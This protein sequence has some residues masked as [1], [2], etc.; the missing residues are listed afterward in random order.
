VLGQAELVWEERPR[1]GRG[2]VGRRCEWKQAVR[3]VLLGR[4]NRQGGKGAAGGLGCLG[5]CCSWVAVLAEHAE[6]GNWERN[7]RVE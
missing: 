1:A 3:G 4:S 6:G 5:W 7:A 2:R